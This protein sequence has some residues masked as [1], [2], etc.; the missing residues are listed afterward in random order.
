MDCKHCSQG[1]MESSRG[2]PALAAGVCLLE[3]GR[4]VAS[5]N[6]GCVLAW[7]VPPSTIAACQVRL[8]SERGLCNDRVV[9]VECESA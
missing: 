8:P 6:N 4:L 5:T 7:D 2:Q 3:S 9:H 1:L